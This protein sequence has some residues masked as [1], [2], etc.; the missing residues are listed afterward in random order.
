MR[1]RFVATV[2][3]F[4]AVLALASAASARAIERCRGVYRSRVGNFHVHRGERTVVRFLGI[5]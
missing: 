1:T 4:A 3:I 2:V 5:R